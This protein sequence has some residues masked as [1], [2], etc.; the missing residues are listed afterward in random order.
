MWVCLQH[1]TF[2][3]V[4][5]IN[6][7]LGKNITVLKTTSTHQLKKYLQEFKLVQDVVYLNS[8]S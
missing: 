2:A 4:A 6:H 7:L 8:F 3:N 5:G 1:Q